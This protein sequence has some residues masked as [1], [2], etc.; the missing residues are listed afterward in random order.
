MSR[1]I[2]CKKLNKQA[3]GLEKAPYPGALGKKIYDNISKQ[4][5]KEWLQ[6]Q[7]ILINE[8]KLSTIDPSAQEFLLKETEKYLFDE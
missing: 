2:Q 6:Q 7:T 8:Q 4:A 5:W 1:M 3:E